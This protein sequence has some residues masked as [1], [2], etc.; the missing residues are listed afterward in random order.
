MMMLE[1]PQ[2]YEDFFWKHTLYTTRSHRHLKAINFY[3]NNHLQL[4]ADLLGGQ[5]EWVNISST[6]KWLHDP[7]EI[8]S[9]K[10]LFRLFTEIWANMSFDLKTAL[11]E[12]LE[13]RQLSSLALS[14]AFAWD[15]FKSVKYSQVNSYLISEWIQVTFSICCCSWNFW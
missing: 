4:F 8:M 11:E 14:C 15:S 12:T 6:S 9:F 2:A 13:Y 10:D 7:F 5:V 1:M 3:F